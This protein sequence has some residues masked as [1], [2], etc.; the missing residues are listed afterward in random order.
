MTPEPVAE[1]Y[2][3]H[4]CQSVDF[5]TVE[6]AYGPWTYEGLENLAGLLVDHASNGGFSPELRYTILEL[7]AP[8]L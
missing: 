2:V 4:T 5:Q 1:A 8:E 3:L 7:E 6:H